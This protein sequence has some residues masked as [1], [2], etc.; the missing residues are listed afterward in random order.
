MKFKS[1]ISD[2]RFQPVF[3]R[4]ELRLKTLFLLLFALAAIQLN[5]QEEAETKKEQ[6]PVKSMFESTWLIDNQSV[7]VPVKGT[8]QMDI[9]H[10]FGVMNNGYDDFYGIFAPSNIKLGFGYSIMDNLAIGL[11]ITKTNMTWDFSIKYALFQQT[12]SGSMPVSITYFGNAAVD[13]RP[14]SEKKNLFANSTDRWSYF[15]Q[16]II[17]RKVTDAFSVQLAP[18]LSHYNAVEAFLNTEMEKEGTMKNDHLA[19][20][21]SGRCKVKDQM[22]IIASYD[23]PITDHLV[24]NPFAGLAF[25]IEMSTSGHAFQVFIGNY[26]NIVPQRN[27]VF[28]TNDFGDGDILIG[29]NITR[30]WNW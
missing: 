28:N 6:K 2:I 16:L 26:N 7:I 21:V 4:L 1:K 9:L 14:D 11:G 17:A 25:G 10:R 24:N 27:N 19:I 13:T 8:F 29:F 20:A 15:H 23:Q 12:R 3:L 5:A 30:Q 18:S 22:A